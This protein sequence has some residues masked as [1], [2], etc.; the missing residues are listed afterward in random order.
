MK[1]SILSKVK[2]TGESFSNEALFWRAVKSFPGK[3]ISITI[4]KASKQR[5]T[6]QNS[7]YWGI[8]IPII[9]LGF[10]ENGMLLNAEQIHD[11]LKQEF[12]TISERIGETDKF[13]KR[14]RS[15]TEL[16]TTEFMEFYSN[17]QQWGSEN[18]Q[19]DIPLPNEDLRLKI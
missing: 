16:S 9:E 17:I 7:S 4:S 5:S 8:A 6:P 2:D 18:L 14:V 13:I 10:R 11:I 1:Y 12:L 15:T 3:Y 19:V